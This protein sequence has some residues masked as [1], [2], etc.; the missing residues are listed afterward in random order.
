MEEQ[1]SEMQ[2]YRQKVIMELM[3]KSPFFVLVQIGMQMNFP[4]LI[5]F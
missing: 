5:F 3:E 2:A 4:R 1:E